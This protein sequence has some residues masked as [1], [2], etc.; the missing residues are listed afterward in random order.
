[1]RDEQKIIV[2]QFYNTETNKTVSSGNFITDKKY[3]I[4]KFEVDTSKG[5]IF[6]REPEAKHINIRNDVAGPLNKVKQFLNNYDIPL[7]CEFIDVSIDNKSLNDFERLGLCVTLNSRAG[8]N[9]ESSYDN[10][11]YY[12][13]PDKNN[14][15]IIY[16]MVRR[17]INVVKNPYSPMK[18]IYKIYD[19]RNT[20][21]FDE[22]KVINIYKNM[23]NISK[24]FYSCGFHQVKPS[25]TFY[26]K[27]IVE[28]SYWNKFYK[29]IQI[30]D[31]Q[32]YK[33]L[34]NQIYIKNSKQ[35]WSEPD[36]YWNGSK[37]NDR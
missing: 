3:S 27:S 23:I 12:V 4:I 29:T 5:S 28:N 35:I 37:F 22:P 18:Q 15:L 11:D 20:Y 21:G 1:M 33:E 34:L 25:D 9:K 24:I 8:F 30:S 10:D 36:R 2:P 14:N 6:S 19:I 16:G 31:K 26:D 13:G 17:D 7:T 32:S